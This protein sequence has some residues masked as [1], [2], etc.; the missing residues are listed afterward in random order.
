MKKSFYPLAC[1]AALA[2]FSLTA[3]AVDIPEYRTTSIHDFQ[4][5]T[6][7]IRSVTAKDSSYGEILVF[8]NKPKPYGH[9]SAD[10]LLTNGEPEDGLPLDGKCGVERT[11]FHEGDGKTILELYRAPECNNPKHPEGTVG[12]IRTFHDGQWSRDFLYPKSW[13]FK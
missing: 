2:V 6:Q 1:L 11:D 13:Q 10:R 3:H 4:T 9:P 8:W 7:H 12:E 5:E